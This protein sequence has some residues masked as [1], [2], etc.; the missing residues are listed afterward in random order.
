MIMK[1]KLR[2][3][4]QLYIMLI[5]ATI[6]LLVFAYLPLYGIIIAFQH[7]VPAKG[8]FG[9][10]TWVWFD[11][12]T[13]AFSLPDFWKVTGNTVFIAVTKLF[14]GQACAVGVAVA[15]TEIPFKRFR[16]LVQTTLYLPH[17]VSWVVLAGILTDIL[18]PEGGMVNQL[19]VAL[20][21]KE[22]YFL[23]DPQTF[24]WVM[25]VTDIWKEVGFSSMPLRRSVKESAM[26][27]STTLTRP[28]LRGLT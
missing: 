4:L 22:I 28:R 7:F 12:F 18:S 16:E 2:N 8:L 15:L 17:F 3:N 10:Q 27:R 20:G 19:I 11:N 14:V 9:D 6:V 1:K 5:P 26:P 24:P 25:I 23:G 13:F 21:G